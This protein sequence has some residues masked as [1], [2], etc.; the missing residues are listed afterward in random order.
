MRANP[1][2]VHL[3]H[4]ALERFWS[5]FMAAASPDLAPAWRL[6]F[7][8]AVLEIANNIVQHATADQAQPGTLALRLS[9]HADRVAACFHDWGQ[10]YTGGPIEARAVENVTVADLPERG[11]GLA[12]ARD[13]VDW[14]QYSRDGSGRNCWSL[15][16]YFPR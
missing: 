16:K 8:T 15:V 1:T 14:L 9:G 5:G 4:E 3:L 7:E 13:A 2:D 12:A 10:P 11:Y 6:Y